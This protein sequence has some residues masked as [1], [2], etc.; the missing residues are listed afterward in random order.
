MRASSKR[1][2]PSQ[3]YPDSHQEGPA[4]GGRCDS[5]T[6]SRVT[7][8]IT[9]STVRTEADVMRSY[10]LSRGGPGQCA[11]SMLLRLSRV[12]FTFL[13][14]VGAGPARAAT[15]PR[16]ATQIA[17]KLLLGQHVV[18]VATKNYVSGGS[19]NCSQDKPAC[20]AT[21][22]VSVKPVELH[23]PHR[24]ARRRGLIATFLSSSRAGTQAPRLG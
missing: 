3:H 4:I 23:T 6:T 20:A 17:R 5:A 12:N 24:D 7:H 19:A 21:C 16:W 8:S 18:A 15:R 9:L 1:S 14:V 22:G 10:R 2:R 11:I 13:P